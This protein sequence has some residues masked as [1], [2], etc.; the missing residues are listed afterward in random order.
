MKVLIAYD[1]TQQIDAAMED[2][3]RAGVRD[4]EALVL[5]VAELWIPKPEMLREAGFDHTILMV[6][7]FCR[8]EKEKAA[9]TAAHAVARIKER[10]PHWHLSAQGA[11][12][13]A[14]ETIISRAESWGADLIVIGPHVHATAVHPFPGSVSMG[15]LIH[16]PCSVRIMRQPLKG[17]DQPAAQTQ[18]TPHKDRQQAM[19]IRTDPATRILVAIDG[20]D[21]SRIVLDQ[22]RSRI[23]PSGT[24]IFVLT[25]VDTRL[26][27]VVIPGVC[28]GPACEDWAREIAEGAAE[29]LRKNGLSASAYTERGDP[30]SVLLKSAEQWDADCIFLGTRGLGRHPWMRLGSV[31]AAV[32]IRA[33]CSVELVRKSSSQI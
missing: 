15:V 19:K 6:D 29:E 30:R 33:H 9:A 21:D 13:A 12:G 1:G 7:E 32:S 17:A 8:K 18:V 14:V 11:S 10:F 16:A 5:S 20:S 22:L 31:A 2:L 23:W 4:V 3:H 28:I 26:Q 27:S 24:N 25:V